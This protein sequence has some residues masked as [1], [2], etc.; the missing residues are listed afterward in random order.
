MSEVLTQPQR[1]TFGRGTAANR[2]GLKIDDGLD[3]DEWQKIG[4]TLGRFAN[5]SAWW[6]GDW[7][8]YGQWE[9]GRKYEEAAAQTGLD[10]Q[11][12]MNYASVAARVDFSRRRE[13]LSF[14]HHEAVVALAP[15]EQERW[16]DRAEREGLSSKQLREAIKA[17]RAVPAGPPSDVEQLRLVFPTDRVE[18]WK[19][20]AAEAGQPFEEWAAEVLDAAA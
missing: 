7:L 14:S 8:S 4:E 16:L 13:V 1:L 2:V 11:T 17:S 5:S 19:H 12:L 3:F 6:V 20:A 9:Y 10:L 18:R 15:S